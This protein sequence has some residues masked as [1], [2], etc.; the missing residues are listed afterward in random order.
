MVL[1]PLLF[2]I[3]VIDISV[4]IVLVLLWLLCDSGVLVVVIVV[5]GVV[6][7]FG[8]LVVIGVWLLVG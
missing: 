1:A 3:A 4:G 7:E 5:M 2:F 8:V 6:G